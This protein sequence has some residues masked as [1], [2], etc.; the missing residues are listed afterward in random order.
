MIGPW[1]RRI[2]GVAFT[3]LVVVLVGVFVV[4]AA[5]GVVGAEES[6]V[7]M[8]GSM[9]PEISPGDVVVVKSVPADQIERGDVVTFLRERSSRPVTHRVVGVLERD[10]GLAFRTKGDANEDPDPTPVPSQNV[11]GEVWFVIPYIGHV[12]LFANT[13]TGMA[14]LVGLPVVALV[15]SEVHGLVRGGDDQGSA[16]SEDADRT[17][18]TEPQSVAGP[19]TGSADDGFR[20]STRDLKLSTVG[21]ASLAVYSGYDAIRGPDPVSTSVFVAAA[22]VLLFVAMVYAFGDP[23]EPARANARADGGDPG[24]GGGDD[25]A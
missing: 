24:D 8:S 21:F 2:G 17:T 13:P 23:A 9:E 20:V 1:L 12:V 10:G 14:V 19:E 11:V 18:G 16:G 25:D 5:P 22:L 15:L 4:Q 6:Y 3:L 7:V